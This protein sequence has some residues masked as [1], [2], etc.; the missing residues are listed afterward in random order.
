MKMPG[1]I[2]AGFDEYA[3][4]M[5]RHME[6]KLVEVPAAG[7]TRAG[8]VDRAKKEE[9]ARLLDRVPANA[10]VIALDEAGT[11]LTTR[12]LAAAMEDW[13]ADGRDAAFLVGGADGLSGA[14]LERA[15]QCWSLSA[16]TFPHALVRVIVAE[17]LFRA[18]SIISNHPYHRA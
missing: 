13:M 4:R 2:T 12:R 7:R 9:S 1:W 10:R 17:Q 18:W 3:R 5:P 14:C 11:R 15:D 6:L 8:D 16:L